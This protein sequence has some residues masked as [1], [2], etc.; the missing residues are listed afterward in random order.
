MKLLFILKPGHG[1]IEAIVFKHSFD[2]ISPCMQ[3]LYNQIFQ[4]GVFPKTWTEG[5]IVPIFKGGKHEA[6][7]FRGITLNNILSKIYSKLLVTRLIKWSDKH[8][9]L[10]DNQFG[11]QKNKSTTD[12]IFILHALISKTLACKK[13]LYTAFLDWEKMF[14]TIDRAFLWQKLLTSHVSTAFV[15]ALKSIYTVVKSVVKY[16]GSLSNTITST[17]GVKQ[18]DPASSMLCLFFLNDIIKNVNTNTTG[19]LKISDFQIFSL[20]FADDAVI[21]AQDATSLQKC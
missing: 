8:R 21:F 6:K 19:L 4:N 3:K 5:I 12:C 9:I 16:N 11:F 15:K 2:I 7:N 10:I 18:G 14:D 13:K 1:I 20:L 17:I